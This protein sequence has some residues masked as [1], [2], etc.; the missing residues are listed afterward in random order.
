MDNVKVWL[1][2]FETLGCLGAQF[3]GMCSIKMILKLE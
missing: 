2:I 1:S 3:I